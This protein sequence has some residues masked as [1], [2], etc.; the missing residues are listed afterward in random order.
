MFSAPKEG[1][2]QRGRTEDRRSVETEQRLQ[3]IG[4]GVFDI[5]LRVELHLIASDKQFI[6]VIYCRKDLAMAVGI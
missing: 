2:L 4:G 1:I 3:R 5:P 6:C